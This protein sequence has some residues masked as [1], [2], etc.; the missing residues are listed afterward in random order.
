[1]EAGPRGGF[2]SIRVEVRIGAT[3]WRTSLFP[4]AATGAYVLPVKTS[5]RRAED[6]SA[7]ATC[8][9]ALRVVP[10]SGA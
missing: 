2:K 3:Q 6:L 9:V 10:K 5:V 1:M 4:E 8:E 7:D